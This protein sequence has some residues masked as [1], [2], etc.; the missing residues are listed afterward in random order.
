MNRITTRHE[1]DFCLP[2]IGI[3][4]QLTAELTPDAQPALNPP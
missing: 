3:L 2:T 1:V 4:R